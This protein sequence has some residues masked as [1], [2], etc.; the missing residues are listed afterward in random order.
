MYGSWP[1]ARACPA[2]IAVLRSACAVEGFIASWYTRN[3]GGDPSFATTA[4]ELAR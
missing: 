3:T 2:P 4:D 1:I